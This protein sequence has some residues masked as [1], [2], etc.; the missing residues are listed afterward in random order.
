MSEE[1]ENARARRELRTSAEDISLTPKQH[2]TIAALL[3]HPTIA[4]AAEAAGV[5]ESTVRR[6][7]K[8]PAFE[9]A[10]R[11]ERSRAL[12]GAVAT[13]ARVSSGAVEALERNLKCG[14]PSVEVRAAQAIL[15]RAFEGEHIYSFADW[16]V[17]FK[18]MIAEE[19]KR[20]GVG[21]NGRRG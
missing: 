9:T 6:W 11:A 10:Y 19:N 16:L 12:E 14:V 7:L 13:L 5:G 17:D 4:E 15:A 8:E 3:A 20:E 18:A 2:K 1:Y 21:R